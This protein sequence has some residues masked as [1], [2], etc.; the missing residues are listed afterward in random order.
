QISRTRFVTVRFG[1]V[2]D[3]AGNVT[4]LFRQQIA[5]GG[6]VTVTHPDMTRYF[7]ITSEAVQLVLQAGFSGNGGE[8]FLLD[9]G[10]P[11]RIVDLAKTMI[12][13]AGYEAGKDI[14]I[15]FTGLRP[16][17]K[18]F[19][20][21]RYDGER[22]MKTPHPKIFVWKSREYD[23]ETVG[24]AINE[25]I[26]SVYLYDREEIIREIIDN[27]VPEFQNGDTGKERIP[28]LAAGI[29]N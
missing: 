12:K 26:S 24:R 15:V 11:V 21:L 25:I 6:P 3:S 14:E 23:W 4:Q 1:N 18:L 16:G 22:L 5:Q 13:I 10:E 19:E 8:I 29:S 27:L 17:E 9:M 20:E 2:L 7:M 28:K